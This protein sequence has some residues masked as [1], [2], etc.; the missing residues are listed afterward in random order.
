LKLGIVEYVEFRMK[1]I[2]EELKELKIDLWS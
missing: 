1:K 2:K